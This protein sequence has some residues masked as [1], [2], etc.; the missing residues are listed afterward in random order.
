MHVCN[1]VVA[2]PTSLFGQA[3]VALGHRLVFCLQ[4]LIELFDRLGA[5]LGCLDAIA[6]CVVHLTNSFARLEKPAGASWEAPAGFEPN[7]EARP[8]AGLTSSKKRRR[9]DS[10]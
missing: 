7:G 5:Q 4:R 9:A 8:S 1:F 2:V 3:N 10:K 6:G